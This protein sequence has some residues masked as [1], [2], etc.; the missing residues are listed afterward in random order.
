ML[1]PAPAGGRH[2]ESP[3][4]AVASVKK[5]RRADGARMHG[6]GATGDG[7]SRSGPGGRGPGWSRAGRRGRPAQPPSSFGERPGEARRDRADRLRRPAGPVHSGR[8][9]ARDQ[10]HPTARSTARAWGSGAWRQ[11]VL[12]RDRGRIR[13]RWGAGRD[14]GAGVLAW[15]VGLRGPSPR[16]PLGARPTVEAGPWR[17]PVGALGG[18]GEGKRPP[19]RRTPA[20]LQGVPVGGRRGDATGG[21]GRGISPPA[22]HLPRLQEAPVGGGRECG[23]GGDAYSPPSTEP[24]PERMSPPAGK[25]ERRRRGGPR[26]RVDPGQP[27]TGECRRLPAE[28]RWPPT[29]SS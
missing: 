19:P 20:H 8:A 24:R 3:R 16:R 23:A 9:R 1:A 13:A 22:P 6:A 18:L 25:T 26:A 28:D 17:R 10:K 14:A 29:R 11:G 7:C 12:R 5:R 4:L 15:E 21:G 27:R 2:H